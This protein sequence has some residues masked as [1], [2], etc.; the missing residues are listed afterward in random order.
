MPKEYCYVVW[1]KLTNLNG[2]STN[3]LKKVYRE[4]SSA[5]EYV[6]RMS[7]PRAPWGA[8]GMDSEYFIEVVEVFELKD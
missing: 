5:L 7:N 6:E 2:D 4:H 8:V 3:L 1:K